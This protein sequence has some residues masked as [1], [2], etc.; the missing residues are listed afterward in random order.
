MV[1]GG[2]PHDGLTNC[3]MVRFHPSFIAS[4]VLARAHPYGSLRHLAL[5]LSKATGVHVKEYGA[6]LVDRGWLDTSVDSWDSSS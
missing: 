1:L 4:M 5:A 2:R 3:V 6:H